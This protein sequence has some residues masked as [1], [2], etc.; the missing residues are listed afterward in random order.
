MFLLVAEDAGEVAAD[1]LL[2]QTLPFLE[3]EQ[4]LILFVLTQPE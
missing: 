3:R 1:S 2:I 4:L